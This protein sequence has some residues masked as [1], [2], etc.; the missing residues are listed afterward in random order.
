MKINTRHKHAKNKEKTENFLFIIHTIVIG[1]SVCVKI[2]ESNYLGSQ[3]K[4]KQQ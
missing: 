2:P 1:K 4:T 3:R